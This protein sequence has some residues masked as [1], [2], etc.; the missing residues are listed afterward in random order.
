[1]SARST[2]GVEGVLET[3]LYVQDVERSAEFYHTVL[4]FEILVESQGFRAL[5]VAGRQVLL[6]FQHGLASQPV[7]SSGG[8]IPAH[9]GAG[10]L[11]LAFA[12]SMEELESWRK[13]LSA[14]NVPVESE[15]VWPRGG[16]SLY[17][18]DPDGHLIE[19]VTP[20]CWSI[21]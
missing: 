17:F 11:H 20:G 16:H 15:V 3:A 9:D 8:T 19:L 7:Q 12:V 6:L 13:R 14:N 10:H 21:Y 5:S 4:G 1:M 2:P 18:R